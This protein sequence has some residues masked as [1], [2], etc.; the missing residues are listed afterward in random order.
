MH[1]NKLQIRDELW[2]AGD[3]K[4]RFGERNRDWSLGWGGMGLGI[5]WGDQNWSDWKWEQQEV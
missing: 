4:S 3:V 1:R 5:F 2:G